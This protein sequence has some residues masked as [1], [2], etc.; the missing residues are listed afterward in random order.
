MQLASTLA[1]AVWEPSRVGE[2]LRSLVAES[3]LVDGAPELEPP[4]RELE[5]TSG[6][7]AWLALAA[8]RLG[9]ELEEVETTQRHF[10]LLLRR[11]A[12]C[13]LRLPHPHPLGFLALLRA[14]RGSVVLVLPDGRR[15]RFRREELHAFLFAG[16]VDSCLEPWAE[17]LQLAGAERDA[18]V[19]EQLA[20]STVGEA[21]VGGCFLLRAHPAAPLWQECRRN[22]VVSR[23]S[24][25]FLAHL[26]AYAAATSCWFVIGRASFQGRLSAGVVNG[27][28]VLAGL[29]LAASLVEARAAAEAMTRFVVVLKRKLLSGA[30]KLDLEQ[31]REAGSGALLARVIESETIEALVAQ[32]M[33]ATL[34]AVGEALLVPILL[35][36]A[37]AAPLAWLFVL[38][39]L[40]LTLLTLVIARQ[41]R[42]WTSER[43]QLTGD[44]VERILGHRTRLLQQRRS[45]WHLGEDEGLASYVKSSRRLDWTTALATTLPD[46]G[47]LF[48]SL[49]GWA[50]L[51]AERPP[52]FTET[53]LAIIALSLLGAQV[54]AHYVGGISALADA[55]VAKRA[56]DPLLD[57][58]AR[59]DNAGRPDVLSTVSKPREASAA[60]LS[61]RNVR[62]ELAQRHALLEKV[63]LEVRRGERWWIRGD[64]GAGKST[65]G[66]LIT[67]LKS[68]TRG[69]VAFCG[70]DRHVLGDQTYRRLVAGA[71]QF[72]ENHVFSQ[73]LAY[74]LLI[75]RAW[76]PQ[77]SD[78]E[79]AL[80]LC[81][82]LGLGD[83]IARMPAGLDQLV[84]ETG[85]QLSHGEQSRVFLA[86]ALL[87]RAEL[88]VLDE[89][90]GALDPATF[91]VALQ[92]TT[93][94]A[95]T[96]LLIAHD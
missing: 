82:E 31:V 10:R 94:R 16:L 3:G 19:L 91:E 88:L 93:R 28:L 34:F 25:A 78:R 95:G 86:R 23:L 89:S 53:T 49:G 40:L 33:M 20:T 41:R 24:L 58:A 92:A 72:H 2:A 30:L 74:N 5:Q 8:E 36:R 90:F 77:E 22:G 21:R 18:Q 44:L 68:P 6:L 67:G 59:R 64:S 35:A 54:L 84:G 62:F 65:L 39:L 43:L 69:S 14:R 85:W 55:Y 76:P 26:L 60:L 46:K 57:A 42:A 37:T 63:S 29:G 32:G 48:L 66:A 71:P 70:L 81:T 45:L 11:A 47:W 12:P 9:V 13:L 7:D 73:S 51:I 1:D 56:I 52:G 38:W 50:L 83:L 61:L 27:W 4:P 96:L 15:E 80:E 17:V 87:Q 75:G 79:E